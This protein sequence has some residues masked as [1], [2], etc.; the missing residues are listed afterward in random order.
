MNL[1]ILICSFNSSVIIKVELTDIINI[2]NR[3]PKVLRELIGGLDERWLHANE[4]PESWSPHS[5]VAHLI[6]VEQ[7]DWIGPLRI[8]LGDQE[9][10]NFNPIDREDHLRSAQGRSIESLLLQFEQLRK[11]SLHILSSMD[12]ISDDLAKEGIHPILGALT[13]AQLLSSWAVH[14]MTHIAQISRVIA[15]QYDLEVG[16]Y[17]P[18]MGVLKT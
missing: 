10:K 7:N 13:L 12:V 14:D 1:F 4:G 2:L 16:P 11:E 9:N 6:F 15:K 8:I 3:T 17:K 5:I 18:Y